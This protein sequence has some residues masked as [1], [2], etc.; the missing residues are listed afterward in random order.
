M[1]V[2]DIGIELKYFLNDVDIVALGKNDTV[3]RVV[4]VVVVVVV[5][6]TRFRY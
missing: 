2:F 1:R 3:M 6:K 5:L 4:W